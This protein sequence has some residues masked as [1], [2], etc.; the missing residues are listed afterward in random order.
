MHFQKSGYLI[1]PTLNQ[2]AILRILHKEEN[3]TLTIN[4]HNI[5][6]IMENLFIASAS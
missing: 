3:V 6:N 5:I 1:I 4:M 2:G